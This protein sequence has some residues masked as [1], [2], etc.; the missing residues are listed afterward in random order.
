MILP[1]MECPKCMMIGR[2]GM[3]RLHNA[4]CV[5]PICNQKYVVIWNG[6]YGMLVPKEEANQ[7]FEDYSKEQLKLFKELV[8]KSEGGKNERS[9]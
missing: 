7:S 8:S 6:Q 4:F 5:D 2:K 9:C 3:L 1:Q